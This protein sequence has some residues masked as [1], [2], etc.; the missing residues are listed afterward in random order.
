MAVPYQLN[1][2]GVESQFGSNHIGHFL[3]TQLIMDKILASGED[4]RVVNVSS[5]GYRRGVLR[6]DD[7]NFEDGKAYDK[8]AAYGQSKSA[9]IVYAKAL[10]QRYGDKGLRAFSLHPG[11]IWT[12]LAHHVTD[13]LITVGEA[14]TRV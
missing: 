12:N 7:Y 3:F 2:D 13:D 5:N 9:N 6:W 10:A 8:W 14:E 1:E 11:A 4:A